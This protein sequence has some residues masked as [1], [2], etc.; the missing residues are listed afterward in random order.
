VLQQQGVIIPSGQMTGG[1]C[2]H[3][4]LAAQAVAQVDAISAN[5]AKGKL[6]NKGFD[7]ETFYAKE[8]DKKH[9]DKYV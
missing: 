3:A 5:K 4:H 8:L 7:Y 2:P 9:K 1:K 6:A